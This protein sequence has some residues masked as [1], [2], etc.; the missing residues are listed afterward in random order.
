MSGRITRWEQL[1][2]NR[3]RKGELHLIFD[4]SGSSTVRY[5]KDS[6]CNGQDLKGNVYASEGK[7]NESVL[8]DG[9]RK[10]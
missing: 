3:G 10:S 8:E 6:L 5:M 1:A 9:R 7:N 4:N 2:K